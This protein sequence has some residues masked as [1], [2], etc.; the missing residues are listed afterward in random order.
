LIEL[1]TIFLNNLLPIFLSAGAGY[2]L[3]RLTDFEPRPISQV[4]FYIFSPCLIFTLLT[5]S[6]L[7]NGDI[8]QVSVYTIVIMVCVGALTWAFGKAFKLDRRTLAGVILASVFM[9][10]GNYGLPVILF[11]FGEE[12]LRYASLFFVTGG[13]MAYTVGVIIASMGS[14]HFGK[15][16]I[17]LLKIPALY[18][19]FLALV[20]MRTGWRVPLL[21]ER[22][23]TLLGDASIPAMLVLLGMQLRT[24]NLSGRRLPIALATGMRLLA[25]PLLALLLGPMF[26]LNNIARQATT[27]ESAMP[28]AV[29][30]TVIATEYDA[31]PKLVTS[32]VFVTTILSPL[33]LTPL[34]FFLG[35]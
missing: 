26:N 24:A 16:L 20:F 3:S 12:A 18:A 7:S 27:L 11:A 30:T 23:T 13:I 28:T 5:Q 22:T 32:I 31:A 25:G 10:A 21:L 17:N 8:L 9:N 2:L 19:V 35:A 1:F 33:T 15:A 14:V 4:I 6:E 34:L 29:L